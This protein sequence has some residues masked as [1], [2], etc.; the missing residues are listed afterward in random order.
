ME[1]K[2][3]CLNGV[4]KPIVKINES[5]VTESSLMN[6]YFISDKNMDGKILHPRVPINYL[7]K[8]KEM[9]VG[10]WN[11]IFR[12]DIIKKNNIMMINENYFEDSLFILKY[13][14]NI[15]FDDIN[16]IS[17]PGYILNKHIGS[18]TNSYDPSLLIKCESY[19]EKVYDIICDNSSLKSYFNAFKARTYLF[20]IHRSILNNPLWNKEKQKEIINRINLNDAIKNLSIKYSAAIVFAYIFPEKYIK[21]YSQKNKTF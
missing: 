8:N 13:L 4:D 20:Y 9:D 12:L 14:L 11:K 10:L 5:Y 18:T 1:L 17:N 15:D 21:V 16:Y 2:E 6:F 3:Q 19:I 7:T